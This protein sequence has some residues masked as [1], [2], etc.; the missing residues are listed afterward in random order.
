MRRNI[1]LSVPC[2]ALPYFCALFYNRH[3]FWGK[4]LLNI[5][6][7]LR[8]SLQYLSE[9]VLILRKIQRDVTVHVNWSSGEVH[10]ILV[11]F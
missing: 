7:V 11:R 1:L 9:T 8:F 2:L 3:D 10:G 5:K 6:C 4:M